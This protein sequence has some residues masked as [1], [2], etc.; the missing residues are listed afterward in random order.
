M[1]VHP[2]RLRKEIISIEEAAWLI[3]GLIFGWF[4]G[5]GATILLLLIPIIIFIV[6]FYEY[7]YAQKYGHYTMYGKKVKK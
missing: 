7:V 6:Y 2:G 3:I 1:V 4:V 5:R